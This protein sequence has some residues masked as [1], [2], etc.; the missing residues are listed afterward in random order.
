MNFVTRASM[1]LAIA[2][3]LFAGVQPASR[4]QDAADVSSHPMIGDEAPPFELETV[5]GGTL[6]LADVRGKY[7]VIHFGASW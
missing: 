1:L 3:L 7:V 6:G 2:F 4:A 5:G